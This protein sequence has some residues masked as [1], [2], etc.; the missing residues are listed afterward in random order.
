MRGF[1]EFLRT[2]VLC[3]VL[4]A[5]GLTSA[6]HA[7]AQPPWSPAEVSVFET[8]T[9]YEFNNDAGIPFYTNDRDT[10]GK[11]ACD[12]VCTGDGWLPVFARASAKPQGDWSVVIR[13]DQTTQ[14]AYKGKPIYNY[15][16]ST[17]MKEVLGIAGKDPHWHKLVP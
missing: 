10:G 15:F 4:A 3:G 7:A 9:G 5:A 12:D 14:W 13:P 11:V 2:A 8:P 17:D 16:A 1:S 6:A